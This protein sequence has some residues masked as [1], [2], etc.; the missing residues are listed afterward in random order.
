MRHLALVVAT[1]AL[2]AA[3]ANST[4][5]SKKKSNDDDDAGGGFGGATT[6]GTGVTSGGGAPS[7]ASVTS[8]VT[9]GATTTTT[10]ASTNTVTTT[11]SGSNCFADPNCPDCLCAQDQLGCGAYL[12]AVVTHI[13]CGQSC[14]AACVDFCTSQDP[15]LITPGCD[16]CV[17]NN[18]SQSDIDAFQNQCLASVDCSSFINQLSM[19]P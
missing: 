9:S 6:S 15:N 8:G 3:C 10:V 12:D 2:V 14:N 4:R 13:Y 17:M 19:C 18:L 7:T 5:T 1:A 11:T 16:S